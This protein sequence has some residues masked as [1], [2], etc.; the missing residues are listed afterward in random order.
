[1][2]RISIVNRRQSQRERRWDTR[3]QLPAVQQAVLSPGAEDRGGLARKPGKLAL[4]RGRRPAALHAA[5]G[6][7]PFTRRGPAALTRRGPDAATEPPEAFP[8]AGMT[9]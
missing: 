1:M 9:F 6:W 4:M 7:P 5:A 2:P 8:D 3:S